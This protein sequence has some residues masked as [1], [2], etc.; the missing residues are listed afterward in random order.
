LKDLRGRFDELT[1]LNGAE[2]EPELKKAARLSWGRLG[3]RVRF[4]APSFS[5][6]ANRR[7]NGVAAS[8][9]SVSVTGGFCALNC[10]HCGGRVLRSMLPAQTPRELL[11]LSRRLAAEGCK[12]LLL[13]GGCLLDGS[14]PLGR[15]TDA[16]AQV[17]ELGL[18]VVAHTGLVNAET[19]RALKEAGVDTALI[20]I[21]GSGEAIKD[22]YRL[23]KTVEDYEAA[24]GALSQAGLRVVPHILMG[25]HPGRL[26]GEVRALELVSRRDVAALIIIALVPM[27]GTPMEG[28]AP[29]APEDIARLIVLAR[30]ALPSKPIALGCMRPLNKHRVATDT[31]AVKAGVNAIAFP[32]EEAVALAEKTGLET[33][34]SPLCCS[35]VYTELQGS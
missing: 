35:Q 3:R 18:T 4:Y 14:V 2:L 17:K 5:K 28:V 11:E 33:G 1:Q 30:E 7:F 32:S 25:L 23:D 8:F 22:V 12:G 26:G 13:S 6:Y 9:P 31:L 34:F 27:R 10:K 29:P 21:M 24:L 19:A 16:I 15:F 20:D